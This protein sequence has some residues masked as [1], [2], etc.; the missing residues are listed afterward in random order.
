VRGKTP[1][2]LEDAGVLD[3]FS[4]KKAVWL[5]VRPFEKLKEK[6]QEEL[7]TMCQA[8]ATAETI[9]QLVQEF[10]HLVHS[11]QGAQ[12]DSWLASVEA[13]GIQELQR[14]ANGLERDKAAVLAG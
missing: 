4:A 13:S 8:S 7:L 6:E 9:S 2:E 1:A 10:F 14:F 11:R 3:H 12:L 5:F